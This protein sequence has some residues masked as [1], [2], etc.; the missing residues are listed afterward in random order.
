MHKL[1]HSP[2]AAVARFPPPTPAVHLTRTISRHLLPS[3]PPHPRTGVRTMEALAWMTDNRRGKRIFFLPYFWRMYACLCFFTPTAPM[4]IGAGGPPGG[5]SCLH[6]RG[7]FS[8]TSK[9]WWP[10]L[11]KGTIAWIEEKEN[12]NPSKLVIG[13]LYSLNSCTLSS[14]CTACI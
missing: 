11:S 14:S 10:A 7:R 9:T 4:T 3:P 8:S 12:F 2:P 1:Q 6:K 13:K 5:E